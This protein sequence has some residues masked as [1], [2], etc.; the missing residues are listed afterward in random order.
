MKVR[1]SQNQPKPLSKREM[2]GEIEQ[3]ISKVEGLEVKFTPRVIRTFLKSANR[4]YLER[5]H[6]W[7][8]YILNWKYGERMSS[9]SIYADYEE[10]M[11]AIEL[12]F[13]E[14]GAK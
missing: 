8:W 4:P 14:G 7:A 1:T 9:D 2:I 10:L 6:R 3:A 5:A 12:M 11:L 13:A